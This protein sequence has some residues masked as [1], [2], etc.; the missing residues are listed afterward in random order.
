MRLQMM[1]YKKAKIHQFQRIF[2][3]ISLLSLITLPKK[4]LKM[5]RFLS[6]Q[7]SF[8][9]QL[10][11]KTSYFKLFRAFRDFRA[12]PQNITSFFSTQTLLH[13]TKNVI[14]ASSMSVAEIF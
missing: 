8:K 10:F 5:I 3:R 2:S 13:C 11:L 1:T 7:A 14:H 9:N 6:E 4:Y 12:F